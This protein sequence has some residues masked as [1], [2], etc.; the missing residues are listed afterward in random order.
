MHNFIR[1]KVGFQHRSEFPLR[2]PEEGNLW[3]VTQLSWQPVNTHRKLHSSLYLYA[4]MLNFGERGYC[5]IPHNFG[6]QRL[7]RF[8]LLTAQKLPFLSLILLV[9]QQLG[10]G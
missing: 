6:I 5:N 10:L 7:I 1:L 8:Q 9:G 2:T 3:K 4:K